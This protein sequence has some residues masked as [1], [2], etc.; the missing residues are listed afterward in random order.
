MAKDIFVRKSLSQARNHAAD[1]AQTAAKR[2][3][4]RNRADTRRVHDL[5]AI[6]NFL[7]CEGKYHEYCYSDILVSAVG[8]LFYS[9]CNSLAIYR[10]L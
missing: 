7:E 8:L 9:F 5:V 3:L 1:V 2:G 10:L 6:A 4:V